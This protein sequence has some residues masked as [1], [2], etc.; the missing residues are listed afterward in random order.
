M[1]DFAD[2]SLDRSVDDLYE[3]G[4]YVSGR[5]SVEDALD[6]GIIDNNGQTIGIRHSFSVK[7]PS[8][9]GPCPRCGSQTILKTSRIGI[10]FFGC[11]KYPECNGNRNV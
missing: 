5:I 6:R 9:P 7:K 1:G 10:D 11:S 4:E 2:D 8:G 3:Y